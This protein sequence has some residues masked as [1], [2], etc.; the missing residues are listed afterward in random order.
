MKIR[1]WMLALISTILLLGGVALSN[2]LGYWKTTTDK[3]P[4]VI[5]TGEYAGQ[6]NPADIRGSYTLKD[7]SDSFGVPLEDLGRAFLPD[8]PA[9]WS[10][11][12]VKEL[13]A[14]YEELG[15]NTEIGT[16]SMRYFV[17]LYAGIPGQQ[18]A[19]LPRSAADVLREKVQLGE[20]QLAE[21][22]QYT[23]DIAK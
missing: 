22:E 13:K 11:F 4:A 1:I 19:A 14:N 3:T 23:A 8:D 20:D 7:V 15:A 16:A 2:V 21:L 9:G 10:A 6:A 5:T 12:Q 18:P 17:A